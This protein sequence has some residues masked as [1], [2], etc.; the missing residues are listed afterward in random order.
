MCDCP[1]GPAECVTDWASG[2]VVCLACGVVTEGHILDETPEWRNHD[3]GPDQSRV[4]AVTDPLRGARLGTYLAPA[5]ARRGGGG[6]G[7]G[8]LKRVC[9]GLSAA[10]ARDDP[11]EAALHEGLAVVDALALDMRLTTT[12][13][14][15]STARELF[16]D[17]HAARGV[18]ADTRRAAAAAALYFGCKLENV[19]RELRRM[20]AL[21]GVDLKALCAAAGDFKAALGDKAYYPRLFAPLQAGKLIDS[22]VDRLADEAALGP[23][24]RR[25]VWRAAHA[26][27]ESL[28][29]IMDCGRKPRTICSGVLFLAAQ[30]TPGA[31][32]TKK[33]VTAA[34]EVCQQTLD[35]VVAQ[36]RGMLAAADDKENVPPPPV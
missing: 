17:L 7:G 2:D 16:A 25:A 12:S 31:A 30:Q 15:A 36:I 28:V 35:K 13:T 4:G 5:A 6:S 21:C 10:V 14:I 1:E 34:C 23:E 27:D 32:V 20:A 9:R 29:G 3:G 22:F 11:R 26:L 19:G 33:H 24:V 18:R 8:S